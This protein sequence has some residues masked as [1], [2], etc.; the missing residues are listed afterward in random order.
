[1]VVSSVPSHFVENRVR[2]GGKVVVPII[3]LYYNDDKSY[4]KQKEGES[5]EKNV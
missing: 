1:M 4:E 3:D 2:K 5:A